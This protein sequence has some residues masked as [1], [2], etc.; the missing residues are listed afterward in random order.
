MYK[1][2]S[3][4]VTLQS[5]TCYMLYLL[6]MSDDVQTCSLINFSQLLLGASKT[7][8]DLSSLATPVP[9]SVPSPANFRT[10]PG[11]QEPKHS[12]GSFYKAAGHVRSHSLT[13]G[14]CR[15][16]GE[17]CF[18]P[19]NMVTVWCAVIV[20]TEHCHFSDTSSPYPLNVVTTLSL[21]H[22]P[23]PHP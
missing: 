9:S 5:L 20:Y 10:T 21:F 18:Y 8:P 16:T 23:S 14:E 15:R 2:C 3:E 7:M 11:T 1:I 4:V 17:G 13:I 22:L 19:R 6:E 12:F